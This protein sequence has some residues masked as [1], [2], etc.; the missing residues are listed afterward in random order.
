MNKN[1]KLSNCFIFGT[2]LSLAALTGCNTSEPTDGGK[3]DPNKDNVHEHNFS[4][5]WNSDM[6]KHW[7]DCTGEG[8]NDKKDLGDHVPG[9]WIVDTEP[10]FVHQGS[11]HQVCATCGRTI[12][13]GSIDAKAH[14]YATTWEKDETQHWHKC[15]DAG[16]ESLTTVKENHN[17][18]E[19]S[20]TK[21]ATMF[22]GG[23][24]TR[25]C[26]GC[27]YEQTR[28]TEPTTIGNVVG[29]CD[30]V[31]VYQKA[32]G[33]GPVK[34]KEISKVAEGIYTI[35]STENPLTNVSSGT[36]L[37]LNGPANTDGTRTIAFSVDSAAY[38][39]VSVASASS[40]SNVEFGVF[41]GLPNENRDNFVGNKTYSTSSTS[42][43]WYQFTIPQAGLYTFG[44]KE[45]KAKVN[46]L[47]FEFH[48]NKTVWE[49]DATNHWRSVTCEKTTGVPETGVASYFDK[50]AH[51]WDAGTITT[52]AKC[53]VKGVK[54]YRCVVC[55]ATKTEEISAL[56]HIADTVWQKNE[57]HHW[58]NCAHTGCNE[59]LN[60]TEHSWGE[61]VET[62]P[63]TLETEGVMTFTCECGK[64]KTEVIPVLTHNASSEWTKNETH[65]WHACTDAGCEEK[66]NYGEHTWND[67][68]EATTHTC[69]VDGQKLYTC[70]KCGQTKTE[71]V[72]AGHSLTEFVA[73]SP[74]CNGANG[75]KAYS[76]CSSCEKY[77]IN[78]VEI[79]QS[80]IVM[81]FVD[82]AHSEHNFGADGI[83][84]DCGCVNIG[85]PYVGSLCS[86]AANSE[87]YIA[88]N[89]GKWGA[90]KSGTSSKAEFND[91]S[92]FVS[93]GASVFL[94]L[95]PNQDIKDNGGVFYAEFDIIPQ[96]GQTGC[97]KF[98]TGT[99]NATDGTRQKIDIQPVTECVIGKTYHVEL[100]VNLQA[101]AYW[102]LSFQNDT[103]VSP[104][105]NIRA[106][107]ENI[108]LVQLTSDNIP[109]SVVSGINV[110]NYP[111][112]PTIVTQ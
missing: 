79:T 34:A 96:D 104:A 108:N 106:K 94:R 42:N 110:V 18:S 97:F 27:G 109:D 5:E 62:T 87:T 6:T 14:K 22:V 32:D 11:Q 9:E 112:T 49:K 46:F 64:T 65:H 85:S 74:K 48:V 60:Y 61:G 72:P 25:T 13:E 33:S 2:L 17:F 86:S 80:E 31:D 57:T 98:G 54:T 43:A 111:W 101:S 99:T 38:V 59:K 102:Q 7:H 100:I 67:G 39:Y 84:L 4:T 3:T 16:Y 68:V 76:Y 88:N 77:F 107:I 75:H 81:P 83:C 12:N 70:T 89:V 1:K 40:G 82:V 50:A 63:A 73:E 71:V 51:E 52:P 21:E 20:P 26:R 30:R 105:A 78:Q 90:Y 35:G 28:T 10:D 103:D 55:D 45:G 53:G 8:C 19:W 95:M 41:N 44:A 93:G 66:I 91:S 58:K 15:I 24:E 29:D 56:E 92:I 36:R 23:S 47:S 37:S 69:T